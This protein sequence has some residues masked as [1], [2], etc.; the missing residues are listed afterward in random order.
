MIK[1]ISNKLPLMGD[2]ELKFTTV[3]SIPSYPTQTPVSENH[4]LQRIK[5]AKTQQSV[6]I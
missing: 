2:E 4:Y 5:C 1:V 6:K 3:S